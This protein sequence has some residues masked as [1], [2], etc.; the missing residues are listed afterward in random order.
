MT[1]LGH[2]L[3][4]VGLGEYAAILE[5][6]GIDRDVLLHLT[7]GLPKDVGVIAAMI[8]FTFPAQ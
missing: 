3:D 8:A 1:S 4:S 5:K 7:D 2:W 6:R